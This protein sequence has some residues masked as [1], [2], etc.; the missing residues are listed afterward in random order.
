MAETGTGAAVLF[1]VGA[2]VVRRAAA[3]EGAIGT[4][5]AGALVERMP[6][7]VGNG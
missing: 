3:V 6:V 2:I 7:E 5:V 1:E 4:R